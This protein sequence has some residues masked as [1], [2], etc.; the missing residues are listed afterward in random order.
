[1]LILLS[2]GV[3]FAVGVFSA[4]IGGVDIPGGIR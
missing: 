2:Q 3:I 4:L 1:M